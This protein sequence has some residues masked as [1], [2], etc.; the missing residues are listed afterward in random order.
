MCVYLVII[1]Q[2]RPNIYSRVQLGVI[3]C[4]FEGK[5]FKANKL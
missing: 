5:E 1:I 4:L 2:I 3:I